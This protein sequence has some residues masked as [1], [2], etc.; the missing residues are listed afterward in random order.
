[1]IGLEV[2]VALGA[3]IVVGSLISRRWNVSGPVALVTVGL[4]LTALPP[5]DDIGLPSEVVLVL[6]LPLL[7]FWESLTTSSREIR[8]NLPGIVT[9]GT[10]FVIATAAV[11]AVTAHALGLTW[12]TSWFIGAAIAPTDATAVSSIGHLLPRR[13]MTVLRAESLIND[14][15][16]LVIFGLALEYA[17]GDMSITVTHLSWMLARSYVGGVIIGL[18]GGRLA[19]AIRRRIGDPLLNTVTLILTPLAT[20]LVAEEVGASGVLAVVASG[21][22][23]AQVAPRAIPAEVRHHATPFWTVTAFL[24]NGALFVLIGMHLP[25][26]IS[27]LSS[28]S[29]GRG[30]LVMIA[31]Y[32]AVVLTRFTVLTLVAFTLGNREGHQDRHPAPTTWRDRI[33]MT[34]A[35]FRGAVSL[36]VALAVPATVGGGTDQAMVVFVTA[37]VVVLSLLVGGATLPRLVPWSGTTLDEEAMHGEI[38]LA[39]QTSTQAALDALDELAR[40]DQLDD[41]VVDEIRNELEATLRRWATTGGDDDVERHDRQYIQLQL[42]VLAHK[43]AT[44]VALRDCQLIDDTVLRKIQAGLDLEE[45]RLRR[46]HG[47]H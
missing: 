22:L 45:V 13:T 4:L 6:F 41:D 32:A 44:T 9:S 27:G 29:V 34:A 26:A 24:L 20:Y 28:G 35:G 11:V 38:S 23:L 5:L 8:R 1:M 30:A 46:T 16:T 36:A 19:Y 2:T 42:A 15:T 37:G 31:V 17:G 33:V 47:L 21:L 12:M 18:A 43:R 14:G 39:K 3:A 25:S 10:V 40:R 7:L